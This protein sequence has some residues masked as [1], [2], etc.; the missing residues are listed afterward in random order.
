MNWK[1]WVQVEEILLESEVKPILSVIPDNQDETL[2]VS[3]PR[4]D[5]WD[6]VRLWQSRGWTIGLHGYQHLYVTRDSGIVGINKFSEFSG[7]SRADQL[8]KLRA[9]LNIFC[10]ER[11]RPDLWVAPG[12]SF[13]QLTLD[14][15]NELGIHCIN[16]GFS[17]FPYRDHFGMFR[18]P[19]QL[20]RFRRMPFGVWTVCCHFNKWGTQ[21]IAKFRMDLQRFHSSIANL[22]DAVSSFANRRSNWIDEFYASLHLIALKTFRVADSTQ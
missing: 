9:A 4:T 6:E 2:K 18:I 21:D 3:Q 10:R 1:I 13:D 14:V 20:W 7:L 11:I 16:D 19:Q 12:H 8:S 5:F 22:K 17:F 15:L